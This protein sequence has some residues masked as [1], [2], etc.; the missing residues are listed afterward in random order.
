MTRDDIKS[1]SDNVSGTVASDVVAV[2]DN[3]NNITREMNKSEAAISPYR[4]VTESSASIPSKLCEAQDVMLNISYDLLS[5]LDR[6][7][8]LIQNVAQT[9]Y[10]MDKGL[11]NEAGKLS[12]G[13]E[14]FSNSAESIDATLNKLISQEISAKTTFNGQYL[15]D[16]GNVTEG[17]VGS[18]SMADI[19]NMLGT[20]SLKGALHDNFDSERM[21][22][23]STMESINNFRDTI[24]S[25]TN[26]QGSAWNLVSEKLGR[27]SDMMQL[28]IDSAN[29]L[30]D[31]MTK[32]LTLI[33]EYMG[34]YQVLD[35]SRLP[36]LRQTLIE[37]K[38][39]LR[40]A[41]EIC[42]ATIEVTICDEKGRVIGSYTTY[43][44]SAEARAEASAYIAW[45]ENQIIEI[46]EEIAKLE[47]L[48]EI[49][50]RAQN[51]VNEAMVEVYASY[52][53]EV[54]GIVTGKESSY[55]PPSYTPYVEQPIKEFVIESEKDPRTNIFKNETIYNN[56]SR[57][58]EKYGSYENYLNGVEAKYNPALNP[59]MEDNGKKLTY[60]FKID[61]DILK[62]DKEKEEPA[63]VW[64][65][66]Q[67]NVDSIN[68]P[69]GIPYYSQND[70][71]DK[72]F[73]SKSAYS[74]VASTMS[75]LTKD[76]SIDPTSLYEKMGSVEKSDGLFFCS[77]DAMK[78]YE[79]FGINAEYIP[80]SGSRNMAGNIQSQINEGKAIMCS[81]K[82]SEYLILPSYEEGKVIFYN[83]EYSSDNGI[84]ELNDLVQSGKMGNLSYGISY[85]SKNEPQ[86]QP[87]IL[88]TG[89]IYREVGK[90]TFGC[91]SK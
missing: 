25:S 9:F 66:K 3:I 42:S 64:V 71:A 39:A 56:S 1:L 68:N 76:A 81:N 65:V 57:L 67:I 86:E 50:R 30:E 37:I 13:K 11:A 70:Y 73:G 34:D 47:G 24:G 31:A 41:K 8:S 44:Y 38:E 91:L 77:D 78:V 79:E 26:L 19:N 22:A 17:K 35:D 85:S 40:Q 52:G 59:N 21:S 55:I 60:D 28:R 7:M 18:V 15:F 20:G 14:L 75:G 90:E 69:L 58:Q 45:A 29:K 46:S 89:D 2:I 23:K 36:E 49:M 84:Y 43:A 4:Q 83:P 87:V 72:V 48:P 62:L 32:A 63:P 80:L 82:V 5:S 12:T 51:I 33:K 88:L 16:I 27:Y 6:E 74:G 61:Y 53:V 10:D 54:S